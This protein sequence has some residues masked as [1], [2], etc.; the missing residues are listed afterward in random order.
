[1]IKIRNIIQTE[2]EVPLAIII[3][4]VEGVYCESE[5]KG[6]VLRNYQVESEFYQTSKM[7]C[8]ISPKPLYKNEK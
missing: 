3:E 2:E 6:T 5:E 1:M 4:C 7:S 8:K